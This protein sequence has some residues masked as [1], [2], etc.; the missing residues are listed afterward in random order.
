[1]PRPLT[2]EEQD[3]RDHWRKVHIAA[4]RRPWLKT[5][6]PRL[7]KYQGEGCRREKGK[8]GFDG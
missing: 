3:R 2:P 6:F 4:D 7:G 1:M 8:G 5:M